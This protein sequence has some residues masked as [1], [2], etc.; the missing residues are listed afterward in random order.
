MPDAS[1]HRASQSSD[2]VQGLRPERT[3]VRS[4]LL[5]HFIRAHKNRF[6]HG[7]TERLGD[8][9]IDDQLEPCRPLDRKIGRFGAAQDLVDDDGTRLYPSVRSGVNA[10]SP[11]ASTSSLSATIAGSRDRRTACMSAS[12]SARTRRARSRASARWR[13]ASARASKNCGSVATSMKKGCT[14]RDRYA[15]SVS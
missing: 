3:L 6:R 4:E 10:I 13:A 1:C 8:P 7:D 14:P 2:L 11:P 12:G 5:D 9:Q 15:A